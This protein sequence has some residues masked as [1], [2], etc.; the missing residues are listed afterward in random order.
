MK[1]QILVRRYA[2]A[3]IEVAEKSIGIKAAT[4]EFRVLKWIAVENPGFLE[5]LNNESIMHTEKVEFIT[6][7][8]QG[9]FSQ[10]LVNFLTLLI[11]RQRITLLVDIADYIRVHYARDGAVETVL[12]MAYPLE[13]DMIAAI[14]AK[15]EKMI[16][17][18][19]KLFMAMDPTLLGG[20]QIVMGNTII[21]GSVKK[22]LAELKDKLKGI[23]VV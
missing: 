4:D 10:E 20:V 23:S 17:R 18:P 9:R 22:R 16:N 19:V 15:L 12:R 21:D 7:I 8:G 5:V 1:T 6:R 11:E 14:K 2:R 13:L 3:F